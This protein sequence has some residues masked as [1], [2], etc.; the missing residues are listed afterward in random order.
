MTRFIHTSDWQLGIT[1]RFLHPGAR[2]R[3]ARARLDAIRRIAEAARENQCRFVA[4]CGDVFES[5]QVSRNTVATALEALREI[6]VPV[7]LL[8][9]NHDPLN[10]AS[11]YIHPHFTNHLP[12]NVHI[13]ADAAPIPVDDGVELVGAPWLGKRPGANPL[14]AV[15]TDL[16]P[17]TDVVRI[18]LAHGEVDALSSF[19]DSQTAI[20]FEAMRRALADK[21]V[22]FIA[23]GDK[24]SLTRV[25]ADNRIWYSGTPEATA[26]REPDPGWINLVDIDPLG[27]RT[28][29][30][31]TGAWRFVE[32][33]E[34]DVTGAEAIDD[35]LARLDGIPDKERCVVRLTIAG[36]IGLPELETLE[37]GMAH[38][39]ELFAAFD[40]DAGGLH[41]RTDADDAALDRFTGFAAQTAAA[42]RERVR[43]GG[44]DSVAAR[45]ALL[46]LLHLSREGGHA[47]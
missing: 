10:D 26:F 37:K 18:C 43:L 39:R 38:L 45:D 14:H 22:H 5:N 47:L 36:I 44:D 41:C 42:L 32:M 6:P 1:R 9:G 21:R 40:L 2:D 15:L 11:V 28:E 27:V 3:F 17:A 23:L 24:H 8:P 30:I 46:L 35:L 20:S 19:S 16:R 4:V 25:G 31:R 12:D 33:T 34:S 7:Y 13:V 29:K